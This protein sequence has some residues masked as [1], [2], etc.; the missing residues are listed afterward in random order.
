[1]LGRAEELVEVSG[2]QVGADEGPD[3]GKDGH[4]CHCFSVGYLNGVGVLSA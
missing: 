1:L 3:F 4:G 2:W